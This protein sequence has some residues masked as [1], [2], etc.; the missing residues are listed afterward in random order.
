VV[1]YETKFRLTLRSG[2]API[3]DIVG[4][5]VMS[6]YQE[7]KGCYIWADQLKGNRIR[8]VGCDGNFKLPNGEVVYRQIPPRMGLKNVAIGWVSYRNKHSRDDFVIRRSGN[9]LSEYIY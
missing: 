9:I 8:V 6:N 3:H 5:F 1:K 4:D 2:K 7:K